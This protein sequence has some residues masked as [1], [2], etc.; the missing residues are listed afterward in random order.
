M[1]GGGCGNSIYWQGTGW[2]ERVSSTGLGV[3]QET[4]QEAEE[5]QCETMDMYLRKNL[6][7]VPRSLSLNQ[8]PEPP[9]CC[10]IAMIKRESLLSSVKDLIVFLHDVLAPVN[11]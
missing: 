4:K 3:E 5:E 1:S 8:P 9:P 7:R 2:W 11:A 6:Q 10:S